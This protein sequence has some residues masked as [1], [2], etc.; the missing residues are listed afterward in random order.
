VKKR[1]V[2]RNYAEHLHKIHTYREEAIAGKHD[3]ID[4]ELAGKIVEVT[5]DFVEM[6]GQLMKKYPDPIIEYHISDFA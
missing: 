3:N 5:Q 6:L 2:S 4:A 1:I